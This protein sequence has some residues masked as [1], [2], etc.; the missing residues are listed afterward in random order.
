MNLLLWCGFTIWCGVSEGFGFN[1][2]AADRAD[3]FDC[4][5]SLYFR[6]VKG[7]RPIGVL[8][9]VVERLVDERGRQTG[10][11]FSKDSHRIRRIFDSLKQSELF[12]TS[13]RTNEAR[14]RRSFT[15]S[16]VTSLN[17]SKCADF[18]K[19]IKK[20]GG[21][22]GVESFL[23]QSVPNHRR[24]EKT[25][26]LGWADWPPEAF[27]D[28]QNGK[29]INGVPQMVTPRRERRDTFRKRSVTTLEYC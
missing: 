24:G 7:P 12:L 27:K 29:A 8:V 13:R 6:K 4:C 16:P 14:T 17:M 18:F 28:R 3:R 10:K 20:G 1:Q 26:K 22:G 2:K 9:V 21:G 19:K 11:A 15:T 25:P 23:W 5:G